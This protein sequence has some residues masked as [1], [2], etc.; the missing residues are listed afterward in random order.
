MISIKHILLVM[1]VLPGLLFPA[2]APAF[3]DS[4]PKAK[5]KEEQKN[6]RKAQR[7]KEKKID[8]R[9][10]ATNGI[11]VEAPSVYDESLL[12]QMLNAAQ[13][14]LMSLQILDQTGIAAKR[15]SITGA[16]Q[17]ISSFGL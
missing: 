5:S 11:E 1:C 10:G 2:P 9:D 7:E 15:G 8:E 6:D 14:R 17:A 4:A 13:A 3:D 16:T 12:Q